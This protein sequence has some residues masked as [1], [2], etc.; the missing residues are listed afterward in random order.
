MKKWKKPLRPYN[1]CIDALAIGEKFP[2][3]TNFFCHREVIRIAGVLK[4][5][6]T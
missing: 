2:F 6:F 3:P 4:I 5:A 1:S